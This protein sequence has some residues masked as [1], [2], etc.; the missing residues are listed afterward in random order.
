MNINEGK[1]DNNEYINGDMYLFV[2]GSEID[3]ITILFIIYKQK[4]VVIFGRPL[5]VYMQ[6]ITK[7]LGIPKV[8]IYPVST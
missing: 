6:H 2:N 3:P 8:L 5:Q 7:R 1:D 4:R